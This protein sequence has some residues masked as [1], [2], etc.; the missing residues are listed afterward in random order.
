MVAV[1]RRPPGDVTLEG[2]AARETELRVDDE[3][4]LIN[5]T[6]AVDELEERIAHI[7]GKVP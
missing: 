3:V 6:A 2:L 4:V 5:H 7:Q 1:R